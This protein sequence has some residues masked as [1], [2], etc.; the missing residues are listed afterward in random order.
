MSNL[1]IGLYGSVVCLEKST[2]KEL[3]STKLKSRY[4]TNLIHEENYIFAYTAGHLFCLSADFGK[5]LWENK[6]PGY[7]YG[8]CIFAS[9]STTSSQQSAYQIEIQAQT[10][11]QTSQTSS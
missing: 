3:W 4:L 10:A 6:L 5:I 8:A 9:N 7:G 1:Y 11:A 2:G